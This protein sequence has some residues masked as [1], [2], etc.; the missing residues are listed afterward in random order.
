MPQFIWVSRA[1][2]ASGGDMPGAAGPGAVFVLAG[3]VEIGGHG[4]GV[5]HGVFRAPG[6]RIANRAGGAATVLVFG[7]TEDRPDLATLA[8]ETVA[9]LASPRLIRLDEVSFPPGAVA[10]RHTHPGPGFRYLR[11]GAL[12]L[13]ADD[14]AFGAAPGDVWFEPAASPVRA[15][16]DAVC[17]ETRFVRFM[18]LPP[19][20]LGQPT[21]NILDPADAARPKR[22]TTH[23]HVDQLVG[24][25][26]QVDAG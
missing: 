13:Q 25:A 7:W 3:A 15:T 22:Q 12:Q 23:R 26:G 16:A 20:F 9:D 21:I 2:I 4:V 14:H 6:D 18:V 11:H 5:G 19:A 10:Y 24:A 17:A 1:Q 8:C